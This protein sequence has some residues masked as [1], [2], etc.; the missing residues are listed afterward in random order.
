MQNTNSQPQYAN[1]HISI[2]TVMLGFDGQ[3]LCVLLIPQKIDLGDGNIIV[4]KKLPGNLIYQDENFEEAAHRILEELTGIHSAS[5]YQYKTYGSKNRA[6]REDILWLDETLHVEVQR[7]VTTAYVAVVKLDATLLRLA[8]KHQVE[9]IPIDKVGHLA[10]DHNILIEDAL[11]YFRRLVH[12]NPLIMFELLPRKFTILQF[13]TL[14]E[15]ISQKKMDIR[16]FQKK[17]RLLTYVIPLDEFEEGVR[18]RAARYY[19]VR[20]SGL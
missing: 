7:I 17:L 4:N 6:S 13:R 1:N 2:D 14:Y 12:Y 10:F 5:L 11:A 3:Q 20:Q 9:W 8:A 16:N 15:L 19:P 18:H